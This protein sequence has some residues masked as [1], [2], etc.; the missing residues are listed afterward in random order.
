[1]FALYTYIMLQVGALTVGP[2]Y[3]SHFQA[4][5]KFFLAQLAQLLPPGTDIAA[6]YSV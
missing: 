6:A 4:L 5:Y 3:D 2:E 1:M